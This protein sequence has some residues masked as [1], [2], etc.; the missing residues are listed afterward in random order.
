MWGNT[1]STEVEKGDKQNYKKYPE[2][3][4]IP[5]IQPC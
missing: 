3:L 5:L 4:S 2:K 1:W